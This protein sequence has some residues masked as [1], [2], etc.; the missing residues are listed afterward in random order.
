[1]SFANVN[2]PG[3]PAKS[4]DD[5]RSKDIRRE[6]AVIQVRYTVNQKIANINVRSR[7]RKSERTGLGGTSATTLTVKNNPVLE[8]SGA[9]SMDRG[10][11]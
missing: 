6:C 3:Q 2:H 11:L 8:V 10:G 7:D 1:M 9:V 4:A 5:V